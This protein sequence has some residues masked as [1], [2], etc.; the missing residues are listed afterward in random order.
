MLVPT[1]VK[2][3]VTADND[4]RLGHL[5]TAQ[6][7]KSPKVVIVGFPSDEGISRNGGKVGAS[8][9]PDLIRQALY[10]LTPDPRT[11]D[12]F[13]RLLGQTLDAGNVSVSGEVES[14][15]QRLGS[16]IA[17]WLSEDVIPI[18]LGGGHET[19][20]GHFLGYV[21][22]NTPVEI[23]NIDAHADVRPLKGGLA[24]SGSP[25]YQALEHPS[26]ICEKYS[27][28]GLAPWSVSRAHVQYLE[29][30]SA[31][32]NWL[33]EV[34]PAL[35]EE[36]FGSLNKP[37]MVTLDMDAVA[38]GSAPGVSAPAAMGLPLQVFC[39]AAFLAG[40]SR[41]VSSIDLVE[42]SPPHDIHE[43]TTRA[44]ALVIWH[45]L[46]GLAERLSQ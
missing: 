21:E 35:L 31:S 23:L 2:P 27:V 25:F 41:F 36:H 37:T 8:E 16:L 6:T 40:T 29:S 39:H 12:A 14:D 38:Q 44:A 10:K 32:Y 42:V 1:N 4:L 11:Y 19:A 5:I 15:Q 13:H 28:L 43:R 26:R 33:D 34:T 9:A 45:F 22:K 7:D 17:Q 3:P 20:F 30:K 18:I 24:H 46:K